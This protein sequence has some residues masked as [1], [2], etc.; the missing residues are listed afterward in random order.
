M[1]PWP[2]KTP[3]RNFRKPELLAPAGGFICLRAALDAGA[4]AVYFGLSGLN[5]RRRAKNFLIEDMA[6]IVAYCRE[7]HAKCYLTLNTIVYEDE[8]PLLDSILDAALEAGVDAI[9]CWDSAVI[10]SATQRN[11]TVHLSTQAS[12]S[13]SRAILWYHR[14]EGIRRFILARECSLRHIE[15]IQTNLRKELGEEAEHIS[16]EAFIHGAMCVSL[17]GRC[18]MSEATCGES[19]NRGACLQPCRR[20]YRIMD[21]EGDDEFE[22]G[23]DYVMSP[24][25]LCTM[26][27]FEKIIQSGLC[28]LKIEGRMRS[29]EYVTTVVGAYREAIDYYFENHMNLQEPSLTFSND[30]KELKTRL[31]ADMR[32]VFNRGFSSG[33]YMGR[34]LNDWSRSGNSQAEL[35]KETVGIVVN[36]YRK[37]G[38]A[39]IKVQG[40]TFFEGDELLI[41]GPSTGS[42]S[43]VVDSIHGEH[44]AVASAVCGTR[45][46][47]K[48]PRKVRPNDAVFRRFAVS[49]NYDDVPY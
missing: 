10:Q 26:P 35:R 12:V 22:I 40:S 23:R 15:E 14:N 13:N 8:Y 21:V 18:F 34:P 37:V 9:I 20:K 41:Q 29:P 25:D 11:L 49:G 4:D 2:L 30:Y 44:V 36:Y 46:T 16:L 17:S 1:S 28:S 42:L 38:V 5:M 27:F 47:I 32:R 3:N 6:Q 48:V 33:Y 43:V 39:E 19:A 7:C 45:V 31:T 24:R